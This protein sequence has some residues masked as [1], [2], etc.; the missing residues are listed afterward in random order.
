MAGLITHMVI[1]R[2]IIKQLPEGSIRKEELFYLGNLAPDAIHAR[3]G[4]IRE[5]KKHTHFR[6]GIPDMDFE[7]EKHQSTYRKRLEKF[8]AQN[9]ERGDG[10]EDLYL[11]Y[12]THVLADEL[13]IL[14]IR[15]EFCK[16]MEQMGIRQNDHRFFEYIVRDMNRNDFLLV[17]RYEDMEKIRRCI[18]QAEVCGIDGLL[19]TL[20]M[21][22]SMDWLVRYHFLEEHE[23]LDPVY[24]SYDRIIAYIREA[25]GTIADKLTG[26]KSLLRML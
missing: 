14:T 15:K 1:A 8:A 20:E 4:Y 18:E 12:V 25:A 5:Y 24:I 3:E 10:L 17:R 7:L 26:K 22:N 11:G 16:S 6:D 9:R 23:F 19:S 2:E 21:K 13:F